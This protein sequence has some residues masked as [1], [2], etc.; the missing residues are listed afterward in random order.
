M[1][2]NNWQE[3]KTVSG[4]GSTRA[5]KSQISAKSSRFTLGK[6]HVKLNPCQKTSSS[7]SPFGV[8]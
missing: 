1:G 6:I 5:L 3:E 8:Y 2:L 7:E 4:Y